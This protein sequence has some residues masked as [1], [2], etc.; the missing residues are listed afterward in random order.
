MLCIRGVAATLAEVLKTA[1][2]LRF[3]FD[4]VGTTGTHQLSTD[5]SR[6]ASEQLGSAFPCTGIPSSLPHSSCNATTSDH[7]APD[8]DK[9]EMSRW[10]QG[11][12]C[13]APVG[14]TASSP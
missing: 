5:P 4:P 8:H 12:I 13:V 3:S 7:F 6:R 1:F 2:I 11:G 14:R 10:P 9:Y